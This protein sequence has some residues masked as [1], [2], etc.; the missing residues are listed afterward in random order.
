MKLRY[1]KRAIQQIDDALGYLAKR[2]PQGAAKVTARM[3]LILT[4]LQ[5]H[6]NTGSKTTI[7]G[8]RRVF[9]TPYPYLSDYYVGADEIVVQRFR[10]A[11]RRPVK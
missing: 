3:T 4:L 10:H 11:A 6:P 7:S 8:V 2:S 5:R 9:L 1:S